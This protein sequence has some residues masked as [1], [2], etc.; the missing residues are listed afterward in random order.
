[1]FKKARRGYANQGQSIE[2][3]L[4]GAMPIQGQSL[5]LGLGGAEPKKQKEALG[6][7]Q[8]KPLA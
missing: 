1:M 6:Q 5:E 8:F 7:R 2:L 4:E 3:G